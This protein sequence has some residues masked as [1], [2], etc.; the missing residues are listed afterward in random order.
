MAQPVPIFD[1]GDDRIQ[2][3]TKE[4][5]RNRF[6]F[7]LSCSLY[8]LFTVHASLRTKKVDLRT[9]WT[10]LCVERFFSS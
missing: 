1:T 9:T 10:I 2:A 8:I 4:E 6:F 5:V 7:V 3:K